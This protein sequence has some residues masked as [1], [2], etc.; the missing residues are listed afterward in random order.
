MGQKNPRKIRQFTSY[1][2]NVLLSFSNAIFT[3]YL[4]S[5]LLWD[6][7]I[8]TCAN[9]YKKNKI[10]YF[11]SLGV[12]LPLV[13]DLHYDCP[14]FEGETHQW[15]NLGIFC[16]KKK[17]FLFDKSKF[18]PLPSLLQKTNTKYKYTTTSYARIIHISLYFKQNK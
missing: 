16:P 6:I 10:S 7:T 12:I 1:T 9:N 8:P 11:T 18:T 15:N 13:L 17:L 5:L 4:F 2:L 3:I 14:I